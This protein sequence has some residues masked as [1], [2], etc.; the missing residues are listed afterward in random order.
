MIETPEGLVYFGADTGFGEHFAGIAERFGPPRLAL[1][2]IGAYLPRWMM[3]PVHMGPEEAV[4]AHDLLGAGA[5][6]GIHHGTF[7][8]G[9]DSIDNP[10]TELAR[11]SGARRFLA[12][13]NGESALIE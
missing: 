1:L 9:D 4:R 7:Q 8:L 2:P 13:R 3:S 11:I 12:L 10:A 5:S 6:V